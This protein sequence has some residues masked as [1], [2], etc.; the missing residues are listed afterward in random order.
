MIDL[1]GIPFIYLIACSYGEYFPELR[2]MPWKGILFILVFASENSERQ[3]CNLRAGV[4]ILTVVERAPSIVHFR[5]VQDGYS[6]AVL[7]DEFILDDHEY[8]TSV[9]RK[10]E[11]SPAENIARRTH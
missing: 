4:G 10:P 3:C 7:N 2:F 8:V 9:I 11:A 5:D 1:S 6:N